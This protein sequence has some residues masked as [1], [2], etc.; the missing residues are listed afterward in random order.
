MQVR[1]ILPLEG[2]R[3]KFAK[4]GEILEKKK[5]LLNKTFREY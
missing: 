4:L 5:S 1:R 2:V 3:P